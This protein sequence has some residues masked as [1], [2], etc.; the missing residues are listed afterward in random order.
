MD[1][2]LNR[3]GEWRQMEQRWEALLRDGRDVRVEIDVIYPDG[4]GPVPER[5][6]IIETI[7]GVRRR[8]RELWNTPDGSPA[9]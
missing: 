5:F 4:G 3:R 1:S 8:P 9:S 7:D 6:E 2:T